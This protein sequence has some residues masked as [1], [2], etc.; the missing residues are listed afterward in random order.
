MTTPQHPIGAGFGACS[1]SVDV[2]A[3]I[4]L[5]GKTAIVTGGASGL[6]L[7]T[8]RA[9]AAAGARVVVAARTL[10]Q[11]AA[12]RAAH[13]RIESDVLDLADAAAIDAFAA[14]FLASGRA[15]DL[16]VNNA[17]IMAVPLARDS[18]GHESQFA[19][20]HL[21]HF[22]LTA[23]LWPALVASGAARVVTL[24]SRGHRI[25]PVDFDD[26][27]FAH[28][29]YNKWVAYGQ[30]KSANALFA[31]E[32]DARGAAQGIRAFSVHPGAI[33]SPL[34]RHLSDEEIA[35]F[36][37]HDAQGNVIVDPARDLKSVA[38]GAA[39]TLWC[40]TSAALDGM[41]GVYCEDCDIAAVKPPASDGA[42]PAV[43]GVEPWAIDRASAARLWAVSEAM[44]G[45]AFG[46]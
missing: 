8:A 16:L 33:L 4:D 21:G 10:E 42:A 36:N 23:R 31:V 6:G 2:M 39:T 26:I 17:G 12:A 22:Q 37:V 46:A 19:T 30:S 14:R 25:A 38:Q 35:S 24:S 13:P 7:E 27:D 5:A 41:G 1:T 20:N 18:R 34:A 40:A 32:L 44:C 3:G 15:L 11:G 43:R 9:L 45:L 29:P 28:R